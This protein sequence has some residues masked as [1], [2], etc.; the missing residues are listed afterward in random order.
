M[1]T[2]KG[3]TL[4]DYHFI[5]SQ[6]SSIAKCD[7]H[8]VADKELRHQLYVLGLYAFRKFHKAGLPDDIT[9]PSLGNDQ[10]KH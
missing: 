5:N 9:K 3:L 6:C 7:R 4:K 1:N 8:G 10:I 2:S